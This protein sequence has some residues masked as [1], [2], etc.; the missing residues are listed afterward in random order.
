MFKYA[1]NRLESDKPRLLYYRDYWRNKEG[2]TQHYIE[3]VR[4]IKEL[5]QAIKI[6]QKEGEK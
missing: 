1:I 3:T 6:L 2:E 4:K 5:N